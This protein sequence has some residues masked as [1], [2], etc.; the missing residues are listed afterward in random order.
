MSRKVLC[1][2]VV[3]AIILSLAACTPAAEKQVEQTK[4]VDPQAAS[5]APK[6]AE[7]KDV[8]LK[9]WSQW[10][11]DADGMKKPLDK[12][13]EDWKT[14]N[15]N[16]KIEM[17]V[18][19]TDAY[20]AKVKVASAANELPDI[21]FSWGGGFAKP[22]VNANMVL[23]LDPYL[24]DG[25]KDKLVSQTLNN[26]TY[27]GKTYGLPMYMWLGVLYCNKDLF[28][29]NG[30]KIPDTYD[31]LLTAVKALNVKGITPFAVG[32]KELWPGMFFQNALALRTVGIDGCVK[33]LSKEASFD[34]PEFKDSAAKLEELVK[35]GAFAK[36]CMGV[37]ELEAEATFTQG[38]AAMIYMGDWA[39]ASFEK[40]DSPV[41][42]KI[43]AKNFPA[44][45]GAKDNG[46]FLGGAIDTFMVSAKTK[47]KEESVQTLEYI[48]ENLGKE[49]Y[50]AG[51]AI[52]SWKVQVDAA[53]I[54]PLTSQIT[55]LS[56]GSA[57]FMLAWDTFLEGA[58]ADTELNAVAKIF[59]GKS[60]PDEFVKELQKINGEK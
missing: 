14:A 11:S 23:Q 46:A 13:L 36:G 21:F 40:D 24:N 2:A 49:G 20:K 18:I 44:L 37:D 4:A 47:N 57:G 30:V 31:E 54:N 26:F 59:G 27:D 48:C 32:E 22:F 45:E 12:V 9:L 51:A 53:K 50:L 28:D 33:A 58:D 5:E 17:D 19:N 8:T 52:P 1:F 43:V 60:T 25:T 29:K 34:T 15:P 42:G 3:L 16:I 56:Q 55:Q 6:E 41:K 38:K 35:T 39:A 10:A 7:K